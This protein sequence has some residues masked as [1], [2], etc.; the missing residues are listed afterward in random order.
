MF[1]RFIPARRPGEGEGIWRRYYERWASM[2][3]ERDWFR[4]WSILTPVAPTLRS[5]RRNR[6]QTG[7]FAVAWLRPSRAPAVPGGCDTLV[8]DGRRNRYVRAGDR[9]GC[10]GLWLSDHHRPGCA[11][12]R[13]GS[14]SRGD[15][16]TL[17]QALRP[18]SGRRRRSRRFEP[19]SPSETWRCATRP[20]GSHSTPMTRPS[21]SCFCTTGTS[22]STTRQLR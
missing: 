8:R 5:S 6:R 18:A 1:T 11:V 13:I 22:S 20:S 12:Q 3:I 21:M 15:A 2:T 19:R 9:A 14:G 10:G 7:L 16:G 4:A 17:Q